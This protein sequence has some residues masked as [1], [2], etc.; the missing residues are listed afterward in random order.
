MTTTAIV[1][2]DVPTADDALRLVRRLG[3]ACRFYKVGNE[4]FTA[5]GPDVVRAIR[6]TGSEVFLDLKFHDIPNT[7]AGGVRNAAK[8]GARLVTVHAAGGTAMLRAA[9]DAAGDQTTCGVLAVTVL[10]SLP[11]TEADVLRLAQLAAEAGTHGVV[12]SGLEAASVRDRFGPGLAVLVPGV[13][14]A[15]SA[16]QDQARVVTPRQ[17]AE[18]GARYVVIG[19][20][21]S[22]APD[23][24]LA[25]RGIVA[26]LSLD[27]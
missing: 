12:A 8:L 18:A 23:P 27:S 16:T 5:A 4:L 15:G 7:V 13:R 10:T 11:A 17:A 2:L 3:D 26:E 19:R 25:L 22:G 9:V 1:A 24:A 20:A 14:P 21:V 6:E